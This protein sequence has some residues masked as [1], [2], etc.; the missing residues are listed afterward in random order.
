MH[1][2]LTA[3][4]AFT[5]I[6]GISH[7]EDR[8]TQMFTDPDMNACWF[9]EAP[10]CESWARAESY[11]TM[12]LICRQIGKA[13]RCMPAEQVFD[14]TLVAG[15]A[16]ALAK[17]SAAGNPLQDDRFWLVTTILRAASRARA[18]QS[19]AAIE[20]LRAAIAAVP[21]KLRWDGFRET[22]KDKGL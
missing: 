21:E 7:A 15:A 11:A 2:I 14:I 12:A 13:D 6:A 22:L 19:N 10:G 9:G 4:V 20:G 18:A 8:Q 5:A 17:S 1:K 16:I 3:A